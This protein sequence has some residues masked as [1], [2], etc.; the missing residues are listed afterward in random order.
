MQSQQ[1]TKIIYLITKSNWGG[2][3][4]YVYDL[5]TNLDTQKF[6]VVVALGGQGSLADL[7]THAG[8]RVITIKSLERDISLKKEWQFAREL[9]KILKTEKPAVLHVNSSK[10]GGVGTL[11]GRLARIP[12]VV[13]TAHGWSFNEDRSFW[14][15]LVIKKLHWL[16]VLLSHQTIAV[17]RSILQQMDWP[18]VQ[19]K[20]QIIHPGRSIGVMYNKEAARAKLASNDSELSSHLSDPW[21][22]TIAELHPIKRLNILVEAMVQ[23]VE[24]DPSVRSVII[25]E[26]EMRAE[27]EQMITRSGLNKNI[28]LLGNIA[29]AARFLP[30]GDLFVLPSKSESYGYVLHEAGLAGLPVIATNVG[31]IPDVITHNQTGRLIM[32]DDSGSLV[33]EIEHFIQHSDEWQFYA[34]NLQSSMKTRTTEIMVEAT[35]KLYT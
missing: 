14:Q 25:G 5:A 3:Q 35:S 17:S 22:I 30:A 20:M 1:R 7:L 16:T 11:L 19:S 13:F 4:R 33:K 2:A 6:E 24:K 29:E 21:I 32:P 26:G 23:I 12:R 31:G 18:L 34:Q 27:L 10:A 15:K 8:V 28:F 9:W